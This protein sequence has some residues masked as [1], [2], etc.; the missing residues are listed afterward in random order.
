MEGENKN[1]QGVDNNQKEMA[2]SEA[3]KKVRKLK[4]F[5]RS[6][7]SAAFTVLIVASVNYYVNE[8][9]STWFL[10]VV[11]GL[12]ISL[13]FKALKVYDI[14]VFSKDW[15]ERKIKEYIDKEKFN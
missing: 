2:L 6:L 1:F 7:T 3:K 10:W 8:W 9:S 15:E 4:D 5:Y 13:F 11:F 12:S 14:S